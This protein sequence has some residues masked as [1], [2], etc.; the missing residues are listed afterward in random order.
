M[1]PLLNEL[2]EVLSEETRYASLRCYSLDHGFHE[3]RLFWA[4][5]WIDRG[6]ELRVRFSRQISFPQYIICT[7]TQSNNLM[8]VH[9][10]PP[11]SKNYGTIKNPSTN[12]L[13]TYQSLDFSLSCR[14]LSLSL[15]RLRRKP[16][17]TASNALFGGLELYSSS[18]VND[19]LC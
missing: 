5:V 15:G 4:R 8:S 13:S 9:P 10:T 16:G 12:H 17:H 19:A 2:K 1:R 3:C 7:N 14:S 6:P 18:C 11:G